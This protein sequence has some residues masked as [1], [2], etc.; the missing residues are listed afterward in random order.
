MDIIPILILAQQGLKARGL[1]T[2]EID[3][4]IGKASTAA[5][6]KIFEL[7]RTG[8]DPRRKA[9]AFAQMELN[10]HGA[11]LVV[12]GLWGNASINAWNDYIKE[13]T[14]LTPDVHKIIPPSGGGIVPGITYDPHWNVSSFGPLSAK[15][16]VL[17]R[18]TGYFN[19]GD[20]AV[21]KWGHYNGPKTKGR[22]LG[23]HFLIGKDPKQS[24]QFVPINKLV[25][26]VKH[27]SSA[28]I[29]IELSGD[30]GQYKDGY[31]HGKDPLTEW[32][33]TETARIL[34]WINS[35]T[36][37]PLVEVTH[38][39]MMHQTGVFN[40][41]VGHRD[42]TNNDHADSPRKDCWA[43]LMDRLS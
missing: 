21:G 38:A 25:N 19:T 39:T 5:L 28:Y 7:Q 32:Q 17:H 3:G 42:L 37:I 27:W 14:P 6:N 1:Y 22:S 29:G 4:N 24:I 43:K 12:D 26:H 35:V 9:L 10:K 8:W 23:F 36:G 33:L 20:Y 2:G 34:K 31:L 40:G 15:G 16:V 18:T 11:D 13:A 41:L 30:V